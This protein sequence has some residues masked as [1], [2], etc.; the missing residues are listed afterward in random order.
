MPAQP[1]P[2]RSTQPLRPQPPPGIVS[3]PSQL[4]PSSPPPNPSTPINVPPSQQQLPSVASPTPGVSATA[5]SPQPTMFP[6][7]ASIPA[8]PANTTSLVDVGPLP[9]T[10]AVGSGS[11]VSATAASVAP[12]SGPTLAVTAGPAPL[13]SI[14]APRFLPSPSTPN[15]PSSPTAQA[16]LTTVFPNTT[17]VMSTTTGST[18]TST[19]LLENA[20]ATT[21]SPNTG[22]LIGAIVGGVFAFL[23]LGLM[24]TALLRYRHKKRLDA[25]DA[26]LKIPRDDL[27]LVR[28]RGGLPPDAAAPPPVMAVPPIAVTRPRT[29][30]TRPVPTLQCPPS[31]TLSAV[32]APWDARYSPVPWDP[33]PTPGFLAVPNPQGSVLPLRPQ[34]HI[35]LRPP[36]VL[37]TDPDPTQLYLVSNAFNARTNDEIDVRYGDVVQIRECFADGFCFA[38]NITTGAVGVFPLPS[39]SPLTLASQGQF[40]AV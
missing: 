21:S 23:V 27:F 14:A 39:L 40:A 18:S 22:M 26:L 15:L 1:L 8:F 28:A 35:P 6:S 16:P 9:T 37:A 31:P 29:P 5:T 32:S 10:V 13:P 2:A 17:P 36:S 30:E 38:K 34:S 4:P 19:N 11:P 24:C 25:E 3:F 20:A 33:R 7:A 12:D